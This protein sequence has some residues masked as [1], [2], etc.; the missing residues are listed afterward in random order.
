[1]KLQERM[2]RRIRAQGKS[3][4]TAKTYWH[5]CERFFRFVRDSNGGKWKHPNDCGRD[6]VE[7]WLSSLANGKDWVS[8]NTQNL[9]LQAVCYLFREVLGNPLENVNAMRAKRPIRTRDVPDVS[10]IAAIF[11]HLRGVELLASQLMYGCGLRIGDVVNLRIKDLSFERKQIHI[12]GGKGDKDRYVG[13]PEVLHE[14]VRTQ[15]ES[16]KVLWN[17]DKRQGLNGVSLPD[18]WGRK[19]SSSHLDFAWWYL[20]A[21][22]NYS[23]CPRSG[24]LFRHHRDRGHI[25]RKIKEATQA[26]GIYKRI[27][28]HSLRH[29]FATHS[30]EQGVDLRTLQTLLGHTSIETTE[31]YV[32]INQH[33][34]TASKSPL[35]TLLANPGLIKRPELKIRHG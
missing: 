6:D 17:H 14:A 29:A 7:A 35:E 27:T 2:L 25:S 5:W 3:D 33:K 9:A 32:N 21:S 11:H 18:G 22:D 19:S 15:I 20:F 34:A 31:I 1:M 24:K 10:D 28:S 23:K 8:K 26:A 12:Y 30:N 4:N 13:F 16:M